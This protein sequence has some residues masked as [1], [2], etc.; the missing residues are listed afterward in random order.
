MGVYGQLADTA[1]AVLTQYKQGEIRLLRETA[2]AA[3]PSEPWVD[4]GSATAEHVLSGAV[5]RGV[6]AKYA[7]DGVVRMSDLMVTVAKPPVDP[8]TSDRLRIDGVEHEIVKVQKVPAA[9]VP[10]VWQLFARSG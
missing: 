4:A 7:A 2:N 5:A 1:L 8:Q 9:G 3:N 6:T 10:V